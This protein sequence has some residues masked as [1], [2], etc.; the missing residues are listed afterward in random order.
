MTIKGKIKHNISSQRKVKRFKSF[1][2][3]DKNN[4]IYD[5]SNK[6]EFSNYYKDLFVI[7]DLVLQFLLQM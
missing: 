3:R 4:K 7:F 6:E 2:K 5:L 1:V